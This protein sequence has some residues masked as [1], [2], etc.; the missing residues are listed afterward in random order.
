M[1]FYVAVD[2]FFH[3]AKKVVESSS[4]LVSG[5]VLVGQSGHARVISPGEMGFRDKC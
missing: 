2:L 5:T 1:R 4:L 3:A